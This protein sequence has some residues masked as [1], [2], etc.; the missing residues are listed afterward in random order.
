MICDSKKEGMQSV[1]EIEYYDYGKFVHI[2]DPE[3]NKIELWEPND[4]EFENL[5]KKMNAETT[6]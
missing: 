1:D 4:I 2:M 5:D 6:K 3:G